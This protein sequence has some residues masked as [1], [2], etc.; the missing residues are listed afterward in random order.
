MHWGCACG[1]LSEAQRRRLERET[2][3]HLALVN[4]RHRAGVLR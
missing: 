3:F 4:R 1:R 2:L